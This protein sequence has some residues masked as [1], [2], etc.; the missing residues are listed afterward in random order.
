MSVTVISCSKDDDDNNGGN[1]NNNNSGDNPA[2]VT[3]PAEL[4]TGESEISAAGA[5]NFT[6]LNTTSSWRNAGAYTTNGRT[7]SVT[8]VTMENA[9]NDI[10]LVVTFNVYDSTATMFGGELPIVGTYDIGLSSSEES[11]EETEAFAEIVLSGNDLEYYY[12]DDSDS[13]GSVEITNF[14]NEILE[15][16][17]DVSGLSDYQ[18]PDG[19]VVNLKASFK[20]PEE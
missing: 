18:A 2:D 14:E 3:D 8:E 4:E 6:A 11:S 19:T 13:Q 16:K 9:S 12:S 5:E 1:S 20:A 7:Y 17:V 10:Q 15:G